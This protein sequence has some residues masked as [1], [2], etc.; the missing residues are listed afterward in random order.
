MSKQ[1][2]ICPGCL[3][4]NLKKYD[5]YY[6]KSIGHV[7]YKCDDCNHVTIYPMIQERATREIKVKPVE[8]I[9]PAKE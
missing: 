7:R 3:S 4:R 1:F 9:S 2:L 6:Y 5:H 8:P